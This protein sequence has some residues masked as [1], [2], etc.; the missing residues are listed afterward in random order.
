MI[1]AIFACDLKGGIGNN[2]TL[3]WPH[4]SEDF[5][6]FKENTTGQTVVMGRNTWDDPKMPK[7]LPNRTN[8]VITTRKIDVPGVRI[9]NGDYAKKLQEMDKVYPNQTIWVIGGQEVLE[10]VRPI[11]DEIYLTWVRGNY[12]VDRCIQM[13]NF[14]HGFRA[15]TAI[16]GERCTWMIYRNTFKRQD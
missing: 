13:H 9:I 8:Y 11:V 10:T 16:P 12:R 2:G 5:K 3:P 4:I 6:W 15:L 14:L 7:P 1:K